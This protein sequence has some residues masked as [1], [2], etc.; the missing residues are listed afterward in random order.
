MSEVSGRRVARGT[1][2]LTAVQVASLVMGFLISTFLTRRLGPSDYGVYAVVINIVMWTEVAVAAIFRQATIRLL[3]ETNEYRTAIG[4]ILRVQAAVGLAATALLVLLAP[5]IS[6]WLGEPQLVAPL[7][8][9]ALDV[10]LFALSSLLYAALVGRRSFARAGAVTGLRWAGRL[11]LV[12]VLVGTGG[13]VNGALLA[14]MGSSFL[15]LTVGWVFLRPRPLGRGG[16][17][18]RLLR[19]Y[20]LPLSLRSMCLQLFRRLD[21]MT[22]TA[23]EGA[24]AAG[25]YGA[26]R[27]LT[28]IPA[29]LLTVSLSQVLLASLPSLLAGG[30]ARRA[31]ALAAQSI[32]FVL[33]LMPLAAIGAGAA[34]EVVRL[35]YGGSYTPAANAV[36]ILAFGAVGLAVV[37]VSFSVLT[38]A[39]RPSLTLAV[40]IP[41]TGLALAGHTVLVPRLGIAGAAATTSALA[42][43]GAAACLSLVRRLSGAYVAAVTWLRIALT[44]GAA[45]GAAFLWP[46]PG[47]WVIGKVVLLCAGVLLVLF[48]LRELTR[49]DVSFVRS[50]VQ[51]QQVPNS[52]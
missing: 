30:Q 7:R 23:V 22:V 41:V 40:M 14:L 6:G 15:A 10:P 36:S 38:A 34:P 24:A 25:F 16:L 47:P 2:T 20:S 37:T 28:I 17:P 12:L 46:T 9:C 4:A 13:R 51:R 33:L 18:M 39:S 49:A 1:L 27:N 44:A 5:T 21:L 11:A 19:E 43:L 31:R 45:Y 26:A 3:A 8:L 52:D 42:W 35:V 50:V 29:G 32:R 48:A